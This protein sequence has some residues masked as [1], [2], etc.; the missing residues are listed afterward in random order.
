[1][2]LGKFKFLFSLSFLFL[3]CFASAQTVKY[4]AFFPVPY[5]THQKIEVNKAYFAGR[6]G[7]TVLIKGVLSAPVIR[8]N[9]DLYLIN[10]ESDNSTK[11]SVGGNSSSQISRTNGEFI[12]S[13]K[14]TFDKFKE[15][16][17]NTLVNSLVADT[18]LYIK[19]LKWASNAAFIKGDS[20]TD[21]T[22]ATLTNGAP[23]STTR[24]CW[25]PLR[26]KGTYEYK[27]YLIAFDDDNCP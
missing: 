18:K 3:S 20:D 4:V 9:K 17:E 16:S 19:A 2:K 27:Y 11:L 13:E 5:I 7:G 25:S 14:L 10:N 26:I 24:F 21:T 6:D 22:Y 15:G 23:S 12:N 1:M 8:S